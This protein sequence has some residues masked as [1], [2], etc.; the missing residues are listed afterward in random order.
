MQEFLLLLHTVYQGATS[1][2]IVFVDV[3]I[4]SRFP[5]PYSKVRDF[6]CQFT[7][8]G[9]RWPLLYLLNFYLFSE[10]INKY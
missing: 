4:E 2:P 8:T 3:K 9:K 6:F 5:S 7:D 1:E 10:D